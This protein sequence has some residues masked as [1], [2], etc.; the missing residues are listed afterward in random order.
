MAA[1]PERSAESARWYHHR[2]RLARDTAYQRAL[3]DVIT[4]SGAAAAEARDALGG[5]A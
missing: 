3:Q 2:A 4:A 5:A 1:S